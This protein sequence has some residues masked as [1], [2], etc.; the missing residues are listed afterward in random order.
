MAA[1][2]RADE[3][4]KKEFPLIWDLQFR[5]ALRGKR[6]AMLE[7]KNLTILLMENGSNLAV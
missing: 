4:V 2:V 6:V 7:L 5:S 1:M 3:R